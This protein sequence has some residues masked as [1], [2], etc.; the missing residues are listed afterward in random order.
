MTD[1]ALKE[2]IRAERKALNLR[3]WEFA[4]SEVDDGPSPWSEGTVGYASWQRAQQMRRE[5][6]ELKHQAA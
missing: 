4:P 1:E 2:R 6:A 5:L 3:P